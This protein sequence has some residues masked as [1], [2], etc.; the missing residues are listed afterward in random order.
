MHIKKQSTLTGK[1]GRAPVEEE[2]EIT[3][4]IKQPYSIKINNILIVKDLKLL[5]KEVD[6]HIEKD[7]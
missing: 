7:V 2:G 6:P 5:D 4:K 1:V 3:L